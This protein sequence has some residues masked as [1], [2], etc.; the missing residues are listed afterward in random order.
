MWIIVCGALLG[1]LACW[2]GKLPWRMLML[3]IPLC[4]GCVYIIT[5]LMWLGIIIGLAA[6]VIAT[7]HRFVQL[8]R[9]A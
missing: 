4:I 7:L 9:T 8:R 1:V 6:L 3:T 2:Y 5:K